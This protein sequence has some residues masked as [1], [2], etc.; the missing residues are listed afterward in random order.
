MERSA[1]IRQTPVE[2][3]AVFR[4]APVERFGRRAL[5]GRVWVGNCG[6]RSRIRG[7][8]QRSGPPQ[9]K[10]AP[11]GRFTRLSGSAPAEPSARR[12]SGAQRACFAHFS[13]KSASA[14]TS[15]PPRTP[16]RTGLAPAEP[17]AL[18]RSTASGRR[19]VRGQL[20]RSRRP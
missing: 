15:S 8:L 7:K 17:S 16:R 2:W 18:E 1:V 10:R 12:F 6:K 13:S 14:S 19:V 11:S 20:Q 9:V 5:G 4:Q 3:S